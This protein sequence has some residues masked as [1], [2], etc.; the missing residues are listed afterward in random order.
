MQNDFAIAKALHKQ[1]HS[2]RE[3]LERMVKEAEQLVASLHISSMESLSVDQLSTF[4]QLSIVTEEEEYLSFCKDADV[5]HAR[6]EAILAKT[7]VTTL[8]ELDEITDRIKALV[9]SDRIPDLESTRSRKS[10]LRSDLAQLTTMLQAAN[11]EWEKLASALEDAASGL[12]VSAEVVQ[13]YVHQCRNTQIANDGLEQEALAKLREGESLGRECEQSLATL[14]TVDDETLKASE[15]LV[16]RV[17]TNFIAASIGTRMKLRYETM[18]TILSCQTLLK[19]SPGEAVSAAAVTKKLNDMRDAKMSL[20]RLTSSVQADS[21]EASMIETVR[22]RFLHFQWTAE[23]RD[24]LFSELKTPVMHAQ[25]LLEETAT[26]S[27]AI[28]ETQ[29]Y[30]QLSQAIDV[31]HDLQTK[32]VTSK[33]AFLNM[34]QKFVIPPEHYQSQMDVDDS[35]SAQPPNR[36]LELTKKTQALAAIWV[37]EVGSLY[38]QVKEYQAVAEK[39]RV[40]NEDIAE[41]VMRTTRGMQVIQSIFSMFDVL[42]NSLSDTSAD[43]KTLATMPAFD[44]TLI[45]DY[46]VTLKDT[47]PGDVPLVL[48]LHR[49]LDIVNFQVHRFVETYSNM[50]PVFFTRQRNRSDASFATKEVLISVL[51]EPI[52]RAIRT[53]IHARLHQALAQIS[54]LRSK[55]TDFLVQPNQIKAIAVGDTATD[56]EQEAQLKNDLVTIETLL[57]ES[58]L[59]PLDL[60]ETKVLAWLK[61]LFEWIDRIPLPNTT[62]FEIDYE[63]AISCKKEAIPLIQE[64]PGS[65]I[66]ELISMGVMATDDDGAPSGFVSDAHMRLQNVGDY[67]EHLEKQIGLA[68]VFSLKVER[69]LAGDAQPKDIEN[70]LKEK[71]ALVV[72]PSRSCLR[73]LER[74]QEAHK[75]KKNASAAAFVQ[76]KVEKKNVMT[77][78]MTEAAAV[79][80][81]PKKSSRLC[82]SSGC[83]QALRLPICSAFCSDTCA[84]KSIEELTR[85]ILKYKTAIQAQKQAAAVGAQVSV[86]QFGHRTRIEDVKAFDLNPMKKSVE[87]IAAG[88][89]DDGKSPRASAVS[90]HALSDIMHRLPAVTHDILRL[91]KLKDKVAA[92]GQKDRSFRLTVRGALEDVFNVTLGKLGAKA[93]VFQAAIMALEVE[94]GMFEK[95]DHATSG[96]YQKH[97]RML[98]T[99]LKR[100][101]NEYLV[102]RIRLLSALHL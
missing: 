14:V 80:A 13:G 95:Y 58:E 76:Q 49:I 21:L 100:P 90:N 69:I 28:Q 55:I 79:A 4:A 99:N 62:D 46:Q 11:R 31:Y 71:D 72:L 63:E 5:A 9:D 20:L 27:A 45:S 84:V 74:A 66:A 64:I 33:D 89:T 40:I 42:E 35:A 81:A 73:M 102:S 86:S 29:E 56:E 7:Q 38:Q 23:A 61:E 48:E 92:A 70:L 22:D 65:I 50:V 57:Q 26:M 2:V 78:K 54:D 32:A 1:L 75:T 15:A 19:E 24:V 98:N 47:L 91:D 94:Q 36:L 68:D 59:I 96:E 85:G 41:T 18:K 60:P 82:A 6:V 88:G 16:E 51:M 10:Y 17:R 44:A 52:A 3:D 34:L 37:K 25:R 30:R 101:N 77:S 8:I 83:T 43:S 53:P 67:F 87:G 93:G 12:A 39:A 97:F